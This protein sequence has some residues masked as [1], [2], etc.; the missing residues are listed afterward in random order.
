MALVGNTWS[1]P[2]EQELAEDPRVQQRLQLYKQMRQPQP[3]AA[4]SPQPAMVPQQPGVNPLNPPLSP[5]GMFQR[6]APPQ[7]P[8]QELES[9]YRACFANLHR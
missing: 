1:E 9:R 7:Y 2:D 8:T 5:S 4:P 6:P 3:T